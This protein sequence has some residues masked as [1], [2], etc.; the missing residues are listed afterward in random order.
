MAK[1]R[2]ICGA[3][4]SNV[5]SPNKVEGYLISDLDMD[6]KNLDGACAVADAARGMWE[7]YHCGS[8]G[9]NYPE[10]D[11]STVKWYRPY[12]NVAGNLLDT[13]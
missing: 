7:C 8:L 10:K 13:K 3:Q 11:S 12:D 9:F 2:C 6:S 4:L 1:L 5:S